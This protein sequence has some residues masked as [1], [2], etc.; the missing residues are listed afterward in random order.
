MSENF[1]PTVYK[2]EYD[3]LF[4]KLRDFCR[5][6]SEQYDTVWNCGEDGSVSVPYRIGMSELSAEEIETLT[7]N[8]KIM[9]NCLAAR[10][11]DGYIRQ[12]GIENLLSEKKLPQWAYPYILKICDEYIAEILNIIYAHLCLNN[13]DN[14][15]YLC[16]IN[17][18]NI[19]LGFTRMVSY[20]NAYYRQKHCKLNEYVGY[21]LYAE[22]LKVGGI[23]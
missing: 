10:H 2:K 9:Y 23:D 3:F 15:D 5:V 22:R 8:Q 18:D 20:W 6:K 16:K 7:D 19:R 12:K 4:R 17:F 14:L 21:K 11:K 1:F 13:A